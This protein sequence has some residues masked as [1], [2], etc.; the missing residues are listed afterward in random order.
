MQKTLPLFLTLF[1]GIFMVAEYFIPHWGYHVVTGFVQ[2][3]GLILASAAF[4]LGIVNLLRVNWPI[5]RERGTDWPY[6]LVMLAALVITL[7]AGLIGGLERQAA[8][9]SGVE[10]ASGGFFTHLMHAALPFGLE[11]AP[12]PIYRWIYESMFEAL[13]A[14]MFALLAFYVASASFRAFR[15]RKFESTLLL[16]AAILIMFLRI[17]IGEMVFGDNASHITNWIMNV[18]NTAARRAIFIGAALGVIATGLR[19]ILGIERSH[20][21][22]D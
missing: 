8:D 2:E 1:V 18:P 13:N 21:G 9:L 19:V 10:W 12:I 14:T 6:K 7:A 16:V 5:I 22:G 20:L 11:G 3:F 4:L 15:A 17:P